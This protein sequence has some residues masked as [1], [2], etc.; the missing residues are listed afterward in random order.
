MF[1]STITHPLSSWVLQS[2][3]EERQQDTASSTETII[4]ELVFIEAD[5][6]SEDKDVLPRDFEPHRNVW[7]DLLSESFDQGKCG[8]CWAFATSAVLTDRF[9]VILHKKIIRDTLSPTVQVLCNDLFELLVQDVHV[10]DKFKNVFQ[11][12]ESSL[13]NFGC[14]GNSIIISLLQLHF[15]GVAEL[16]C[17]PYNTNIYNKRAVDTN[18]GLQP[19]MDAVGGFGF[20]ESNID[21][22]Q[23]L[24]TRTRSISCFLYNPNTYEYPIKY[25]INSFR[26]YNVY[27]YGSPCQNFFSL[28]NYIIRDGVIDNRNIMY[29][30]FKYGP[31]VTTFLVY[32]DFYEFSPNRDGVY[33]HK[34]GQLVGGHAVEIVGWGIYRD[35]PFWWIKNSWGSQYGEM[36]YFRFLRG[37]DHC[38]IESNVVSTMPNFF[39]DFSTPERIARFHENVFKKSHFHYRNSEPPTSYLSIMKKV[40]ELHFTSFISDEMIRST[41]D[42]YGIFGFYVLRAL[43]VVNTN[44]V[45]SNG[46]N[47]VNLLVFPGLDYDRN[48]ISLSYSDIWKPSYFAGRICKDTIII[49]KRQLDKWLFVSL[50]FMMLF[51]F[52][53][54]HYF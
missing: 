43:G 30:I 35:T 21:N 44:V 4:D 22:F 48:R 20:G 15:F 10:K 12:N 50:F 31:V 28:F 27:Q 36:G 8:S 24:S 5:Y 23:D 54:R 45:L 18:I 9:N 29:D 6:R 51:L 7:K 37:Q 52:L 39:M 32:S 3:Q 53:L 13:N 16:S 33:I 19:S 2:S 1:R 14:S 41:F 38:A 25:C 17:F 49:A 34:R 40:Y 42:K 47:M 46:Y 26:N 11:F